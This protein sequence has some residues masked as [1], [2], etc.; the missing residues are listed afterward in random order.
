KVKI[1]SPTE[2]ANWICC[3]LGARDHY[4]VPRSLHQR[5]LL[6]A[7]ITEAWVPPTGALARLSG[8]LGERFRQRYDRALADVNVLHFSVSA[9]MYEMRASFAKSR[10]VWDSIIA[11]N[12]WFQAKAIRH[13]R[14]FARED[15]QISN[16]VV[17]AYS[18][19]A[20]EILRVARELG[21]T[22]VL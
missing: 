20:R 18:Y 7:L 6:K 2:G 15:C 22:T 9:I 19:A 4:S 17:F 21:C 8:E 1:P 3:Q 12:N 16:K 14:A 10:N 11:R 5:A 13:L